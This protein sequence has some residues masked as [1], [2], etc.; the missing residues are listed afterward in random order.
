[1]LASFTKQTKQFEIFHYLTIIE[2]QSLFMLLL[3]CHTSPGFKQAETLTFFFFFN[4]KTQA[5]KAVPLGYMF[6][7]KLD[8]IKNK[9]AT[10]KCSVSYS[11]IGVLSLLSSVQFSCSV[12]SDS[13][14]P[15][16][17][18][19]ARPPCP[20]PSPGVHYDSRPSSQ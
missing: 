5:D 2:G 14:P 8:T 18:Q 13:L 7:L 4:S 15:H 17:L 16:E 19:H 12:M 11:V 20:S 3:D 9:S 10:V 1:M 6:I